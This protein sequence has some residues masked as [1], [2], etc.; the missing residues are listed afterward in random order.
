MAAHPRFTG[1]DSTVRP[2]KSRANSSEPPRAHRLICCE[3]R[4]GRPTRPPSS[5][6]PGSDCRP[7]PLWAS[8]INRERL[9]H[10]ILGRGAC[11][12]DLPTRSR[13]PI[14]SAHVGPRLPRRPRSLAG[15]LPLVA[16]DFSLASSASR[17]PPRPR[18]G[19]LPDNRA[20]WDPPVTPDMDPSSHARVWPKSL[21]VLRSVNLPPD[22]QVQTCSPPNLWASGIN[23]E[24][25]IVP[26]SGPWCLLS[27]I[28]N[29]LPG[30]NPV[31]TC[32]SKSAPLS[33]I[34]AGC[35]PP[36][37]PDFSLASSASRN[38]PGREEVP[39]RTTGPAGIHTSLWT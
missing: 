7:P 35:L 18:R 30:T 17:R 9:V 8:G 33:A 10:P 28:P 15:C 25:L 3:C 34:P 13:E 14:P 27:W 39:S 38:P 23:R 22:R 4:T 26:I 31:C 24:R 11:L 37:A 16:P 19:H 5:R 36:A 2:P 21:P 12:P 20:G 29:A 1:Q 6:S 32:R